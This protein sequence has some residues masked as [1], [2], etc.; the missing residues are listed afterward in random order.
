MLIVH[1][2]P[3]SCYRKKLENL[4]HLNC[5]FHIRQIWIQLI[6]ACGKY[7]KSRCTKHTSL[8]WSYRWRHWW[9]AAAMTTWSSWDHSVH[10]H[11]FSSFRS[12]MRILYN[13]SCNTSNKSNLANLGPQSSEFCK[14]F[15]KTFWSLFSGY[16][17]ENTQRLQ[18]SD[19]AKTNN[20]SKKLIYLYTTLILL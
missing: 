3:F 4:S 13:F 8:I 12:A 6:T 11:W 14:I 9:M 15:H 17:E 20:A 7:C 2:L 1:V 5:V 16:T 19:K 18:T 10:S